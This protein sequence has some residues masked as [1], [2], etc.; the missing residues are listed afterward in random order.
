MHARAKRIVVAGGGT[1]G[2][3]FPALAVARELRERHPDAAISFIGGHRGLEGRLVPQ[4]GF[5]LRTL[6]LSGI[7]GAPLIG[8]VT[9]AAFAGAGVLRCAA[10]MLRERP[11][12]VIGVGGYASGPAVAA[13]RL[14]F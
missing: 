11:D 6:P 9:G 14:L 2:H 3:L 12:L 1:G 8:R 13:A 7:K 10:W 4:H 5:P